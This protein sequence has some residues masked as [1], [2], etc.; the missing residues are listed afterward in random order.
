M[1][2]YFSECEQTFSRFTHFR[3]EK[4]NVKLLICLVVD[5]HSTLKFKESRQG[6]IRRTR[7]LHSPPLL[8][9]HLPS[10][11]LSSPPLSR[12]SLSSFFPLPL[13]FPFFS[14]H[15]LPLEVGPI[16]QLSGGALKLPQRV[17]AEPGQQTVFGE[18]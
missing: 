16:L 11:S 17:R 8:S 6:R 3:S 15:P 1:I 9:F 13:L 14:S 4:H 2:V 7:R 10:L 18:F 5:R 12:P